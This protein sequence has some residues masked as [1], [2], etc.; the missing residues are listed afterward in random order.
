MPFLRCSLLRT[1]WR[2]RRVGAAW[3]AGLVALLMA[4]QGAQADEHIWTALVLATDVPK[5]KNPPA[6]LAKVAPKIERF[7][8]FNQLEIIGSATKTID[9]EVERWLVPTQN[10]YLCAKSKRTG[11]SKYLLDV[12]L[13]QDKRCLVETQ[14]RLGANSPLVIRGP[15]HERGQLLIV[16]QVVP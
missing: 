15:V 13:Y 12:S 9:E 2:G 11:E 16:L 3:C 6:E 8:G 10:F 4:A 1:P 14:T 5:P 7:F